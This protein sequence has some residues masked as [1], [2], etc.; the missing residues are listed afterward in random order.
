MKGDR[1]SGGARW[2]DLRHDIKAKSVSL[3]TAVGLLRDSPASE[4]REL[5]ALMAQAAGDIA[6]YVSELQRELDGGAPAGGP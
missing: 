6:R 4:R 3:Q 2:D 1:R 5:L